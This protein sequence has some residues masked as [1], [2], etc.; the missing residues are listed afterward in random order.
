[1][2]YDQFFAATGL[3]G[4]KDSWDHLPCFANRFTVNDKVNTFELID[5]YI[6]I[7]S[8]RCDN[9]VFLFSVTEQ[10][11]CWQVWAD[12]AKAHPR[13][14][15]I[16]EGGSIHGKYMCRMYIY[17]KPANQRKFHA[18]NIQNYRPR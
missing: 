17:T 16:V 2:N 6:K 7:A 5:A 15:K 10:D 13:T 14:F 4:M 3:Y 1:M 18:D 11:K 12:Y 9:D 8:A